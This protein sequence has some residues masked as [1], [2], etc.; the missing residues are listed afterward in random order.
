MWGMS[1]WGRVGKSGKVI[2]DPL[3]TVSPCLRK[4]NRGGKFRRGRPGWSLEEKNIEATKFDSL[5]YTRAEEEG[6]LTSR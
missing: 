4:K 3:W 5:R 1:S 2:Q 6:L